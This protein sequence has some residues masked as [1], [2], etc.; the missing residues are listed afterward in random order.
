MDTSHLNSGSRHSA[1]DR[2]AQKRHPGFGPLKEVAT[3]HASRGDIHRNCIEERVDVCLVAGDIFSDRHPRDRIHDS[4]EH[5]AATFEEFSLGGGS[6]VAL[7]GNH[8]NE[9]FCQTLKQVMR[10]ASPAPIRRGDLVSGGR[11]YLATEPSFLRLKDVNNVEVQF[12]LMPY[13]TITRYL[14]NRELH[15]SFLRGCRMFDTP[16]ASN[17]W[18]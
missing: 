2:R 10:L 4:I 5:L 8:D 16:A 18:T 17:D 6:V 3:Q 9:S 12:V 15:F 1:Q 14:G 7:T 11:W 13:P